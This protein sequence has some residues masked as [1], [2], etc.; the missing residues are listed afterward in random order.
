MDPKYTMISWTGKRVA[1]RETRLIVITP[2][3]NRD[4]L[5]PLTA[6]DRIE[7][8]RGPNLLLYGSGCHG[9][10]YQYYHAESAGE[11]HASVRTDAT[12]E[13]KD[14]GNTGQGSFFAAGPLADNLLGTD[15]SPNDFYQK[16][17]S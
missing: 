6:I 8:V 10:G 17:L 13:R 9:R 11:W 3:L 5:P 1:S 2:E 16:S 4:G 15:E 12:I 14:S 7:V